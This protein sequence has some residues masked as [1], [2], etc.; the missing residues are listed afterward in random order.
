MQKKLEEEGISTILAGTMARL[1]KYHS[2]SPEDK[3]FPIYVVDQYDRLAKPY[4]IEETTE[5]FHKYEEIRR[6]ERLYVDPELYN[7]AEKIII[8]QKL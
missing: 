4:P 6:I 5:I 8:D 3:A 1:S 7:K 2:S